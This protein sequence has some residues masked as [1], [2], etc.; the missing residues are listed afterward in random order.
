MSG[1]GGSNLPKSKE[2]SIPN[3]LSGR[4]VATLLTALFLCLVVYGYVPEMSM[5]L[6]IILSTVLFFYGSA[7]MAKSWIHVRDKSFV[8]NVF[9]VGFAVRISWALYLYFF[10]NPEHYG[11]SY[12]S[13]GDVDWYIPFGQEIAEWLSGEGE[14]TFSELIDRWV[15]AIDDVG[16]PFW[17]GIVYFLTGNESDVFIPFLLK[18]IIGA[19]CAVCI[20]N[21]A[22]RHYGEGVARIA[23]L[24]VCLNPNM[25]YWCGN[26]MKEA[27]MTFICCIAV[28]SFDKALSSGGKLTFKSLIPGVLAG[29]YLFLFRIVLGLVVFLAVFAHIVM[30]SNRVMSLGKKIIA[31]IL[32]ALTL[33]FS[34]GDKL[35]S[36]SRS[37]VETVQSDSQEKNMEWRGKRDGGNSFA[38]YA[39]AAVFAPLI[40]TIPFPTFN[41]ANEQQ[42]VQI[43]LAGGSF[44]KNILSFFIIY[45][46]IL[47]LLSG[48]W[49]LH[50][51]IIAYTC[52]YLACLV[53]SD[54]AQSG[55]FHM[56]VLP[57][58]ML[59]AAYGIQLAKTNPRIKRWFPIVLVIEVVICLGWNWFKLKGRGMI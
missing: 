32:V 58:L 35:V 16:Y 47:M 53:L 20:Y 28:N 44:I 39:G 22:K 56:P 45:I 21:I 36:Q 24:F 9:W 5:I 46:L 3:W 51:F 1:F 40:F 30:A 6:T 25:I 33:F 4:S 12:G 27:E 13:I 55:R 59:F 11:N 17:L 34:I 23:A 41:V 26:M 19:Y 18:S 54:F 37:L 42:I 14:I 48:D 8:R 10:F 52:G 29:M 31:G 43:Q 15:F 7:S 38:K 2:L 50:V 49:R 57:M